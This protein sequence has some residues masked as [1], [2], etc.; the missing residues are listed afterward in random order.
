M[1]QHI[2]KIKN[3]REFKQKLNSYRK[4][5]GIQK[6]YHPLLNC[7]IVNATM[8]NFRGTHSKLFRH[9]CVQL[10]RL[11]KHLKW[12][13]KSVNVPIK[14][15]TLEPKIKVTKKFADWCR[16]DCYIFIWCFDKNSRGTYVRSSLDPK[17]WDYVKTDISLDG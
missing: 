17:L 14:K 3:L 6:S 2:L 9:P 10:E 12:L 5:K 11:E 7:N 1:N 16:R 4:K 8:L 13:P 15:K